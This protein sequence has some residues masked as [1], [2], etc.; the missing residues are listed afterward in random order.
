MPVK[1]T[2]CLPY[3]SHSGFSHENFTLILTCWFPAAPIQLS[4][5]HPSDCTFLIYSPEHHLALS[6]PEQSRLRG[7][8]MAAAAPHKEK[9]R[10]EQHWAL[11]SVKV[12]AW[13]CVRGGVGGGQGQ[14]L[15][16]RVVGM[17]QAAQGS[18]HSPKCWGSRRVWTT[19][20]DIGFGFSVVLFGAG[21]WILWVSSNFGYSMMLWSSSA[22]ISRVTPLCL[23][24]L[25]PPACGRCP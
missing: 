1:V 23:A 9:R 3:S 7:C 6:S 4:S 13:C 10:E 15:P 12:T 21:N 19:L 24:Q 20:S 16:Q 25:L 11:L 18:E 22:I 14:S 2:S 17:E 8:L 5:E